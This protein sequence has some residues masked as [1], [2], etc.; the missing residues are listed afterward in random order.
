MRFLEDNGIEF[1]KLDIRE[2]PPSKSEIR[3]MLDHMGKEPRRLFNT[4]G[5]DYRS[6]NMKDKLEGMSDDDVIDLLGSNG[7]LIRRPFVIGK[8]VML[9][10]FLQEVWEAKLL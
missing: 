1:S 7:N 6:M 9:I 5:R 8:D 3:R 2:S 4:S 10:G